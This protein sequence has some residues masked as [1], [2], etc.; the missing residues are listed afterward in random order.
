MARIKILNGKTEGQ[1]YDIPLGERR[2]LGR[3]QKADIPIPDS[4]MSRKHCVVESSLTGY[5]IG[6]LGSS[7]G[8][9]VRD[10]RINEAILT[11]GDTAMVGNTRFIFFDDAD[12][13]KVETQSEIESKRTKM[14]KARSA[15]KGN[16]DG[17]ISAKASFCETCGLHI[18]VEEREDK[19]A[20]QEDGFWMCAKCITEYHELKDAGTVQDIA[21]FTTHLR[22]KKHMGGAD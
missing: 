2:V 20:R 8:T 19:T 1:E 4:K 17:Y 11:N 9:F 13:D 6:D 7:N 10:T 3:S 12:Y 15:S 14:A 21:T 5:I 18:T 22:K 16:Q